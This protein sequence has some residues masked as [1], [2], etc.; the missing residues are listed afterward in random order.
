MILNYLKQTWR[1]LVKNKT[2]SILNI[3]GLSAGLI[4]FAFI[5]VWVTDELSYDMF[6]KNYSR[7]V[8]LT[9]IA[10]TE[11]GIS[12]SA[13]SSAPMAKA[14]KD[15]YPEVENTVRF[16]MRE[17]IV[18]LKDKQLLESAIL[19]T[20]PSFFDVFSFRLTRGN[21]STALS[22]PYSIILTKSAAKKYFGD[23]DPMGQVLTINMYDSAGLGA[24]YKVTG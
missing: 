15:D 4:C 14:L 10:K 13:V 16:D 12:A 1:S 9:G 7:I 2:Y 3:V 18:R 23:A 5:A 11:S 19:I 8:R 21:V 20:D 22:E 17:E 24:Q 6:N